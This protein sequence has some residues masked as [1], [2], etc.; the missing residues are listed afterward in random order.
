MKM[1]FAPPRRT[2]GDVVLPV[3]PPEVDHSVGEGALSCDV[4]LRAIH[5]LEKQ[6]INYQTDPSVSCRVFFFFFFLDLRTLMKL[7]LM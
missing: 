1:V 3:H 5:A 7:A 2:Y 4:G 6:M